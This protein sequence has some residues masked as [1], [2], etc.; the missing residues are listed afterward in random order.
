MCQHTSP[1]VVSGIVMF[2]T[3]KE[4]YVNSLLFTILVKVALG[5][6]IYIVCLAITSLLLNKYKDEFLT[7]NKILNHLIQKY[8]IK[9]MNK[10]KNGRN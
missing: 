4:I 3:V 10:I 8:Y 9:L 1:F 7:V 6:V 5:S 2:I